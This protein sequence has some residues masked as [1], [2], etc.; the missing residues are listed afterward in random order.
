MP[1]CELHK[2]PVENDKSTE[3]CV[4]NT[5]KGRP[6]LKY[7][8]YGLCVWGGRIR[9]IHDTA[10]SRDSAVSC[11]QTWAP[12]ENDSSSYSSYVYTCVD[13][14]VCTL[15]HRYCTRNRIGNL[16]RERI[17]V[18]RTAAANPRYAY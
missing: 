11:Y 3:T 13:S 8:N 6:S 16:S 4:R 17:K 1:V 9:H 18:I 12:S 10:N 15:N 5:E 14:D 7:I 2:Y